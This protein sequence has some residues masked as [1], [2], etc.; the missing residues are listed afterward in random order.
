VTDLGPYL[1]KNK[2]GFRIIWDADK[3]I[4]DLRACAAQAASPYNDGYS[5]WY[6]KKDLLTV[7]YAL[8]EMLERCPTFST[9]E[10]S[11]HQDMAKQKMWK[12]LNDKM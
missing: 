10:G 8:D 5:A 7:K 4:S 6:C 1:K 2:M 9:D 3:I 12:V 11:F